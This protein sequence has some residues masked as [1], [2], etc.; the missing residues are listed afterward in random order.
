MPLPFEM[1]VLSIYLGVNG[2]LDATP[3]EKVGE[4][5]ANF[6]DYAKKMH[7]ND[8][9]KPLRESKELKEEI[10]KAIESAIAAFKQTQ[11]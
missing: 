7:E 1:Q 3:K 9:V 6:L 10:V 5:V 11:K 4:T 2:H 8:V